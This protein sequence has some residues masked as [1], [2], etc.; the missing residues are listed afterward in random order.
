[1]LQPQ[2][3]VGT[4]DHHLG[5]RE[6]LERFDG[7]VHALAGGLGNSEGRNFE[8]QVAIAANDENGAIG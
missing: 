3:A 7:G 8:P 5:L 4:E 1:M 6:R 2:I